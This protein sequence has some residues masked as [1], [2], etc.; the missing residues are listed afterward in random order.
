MQSMLSDAIY[1]DKGKPM[2]FNFPAHISII[3]KF[4]AAFL[5]LPFFLNSRNFTGRL[6]RKAIHIPQPKRGQGLARD[7]APGV[8][9]RS[10]SHS[11]QTGTN[12]GLLHRHDDESRLNQ[13]VGHS[14]SFCVVKDRVD[15]SSTQIKFRL[16]GYQHETAPYSDRRPLDPWQLSLCA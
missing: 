6:Y 15:P 8:G 16:Q 11:P 13:P 12:N 5:S 10:S 2:P 9:S 3:C 14:K 7:N 1:H 4:S